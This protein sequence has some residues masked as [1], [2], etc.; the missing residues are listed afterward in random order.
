MATSSQAIGIG[1]SAHTFDVDLVLR[2]FEDNGVKLIPTYI[3]DV[4]SKADA[5]RSTTATEKRCRLFDEFIKSNRSGLVTALACT[6]NKDCVRVCSMYLAG[7]DRFRAVVL[8][9]FEETFPTTTTD[10]QGSSAELAIRA[11]ESFYSSAPTSEFSERLYEHQRT[12]LLAS[13]AFDALTSVDLQPPDSPVGERAEMVT[14]P[15]RPS[16]R[17]I[18]RARMKRPS[19]SIDDTAFHNLGYHRPT[20]PLECNSMVDEVMDKLKGILRVRARPLTYIVPAFISS[21]RIIFSIWEI[22]T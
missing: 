20:T 19:L 14:S 7:D 12:F 17:E 1:Q 21:V 5:F 13:R 8:D 3:Y 10:F 2:S 11:F 9:H 18:K 4:Q 15:K 16:Q 6:L 22:L